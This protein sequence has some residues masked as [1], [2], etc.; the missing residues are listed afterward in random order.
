MRPRFASDFQ[1]RSV[2]FVNL[3]PSNFILLRKRRRGEKEGGGEG[4]SNAFPEGKKK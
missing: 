4:E 2:A 1:K 3:R